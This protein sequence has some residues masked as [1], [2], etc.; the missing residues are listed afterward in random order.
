MRRNSSSGRQ[1]L[2]QESWDACE[3]E[4]LEH[5]MLVSSCGDIIVPKVVGCVCNN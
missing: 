1:E 3:N 4:V 5:Q 2:A